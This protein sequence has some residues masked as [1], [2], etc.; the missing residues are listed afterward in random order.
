MF[1]V[2]FS[3]NRNWQPLN[4]AELKDFAAVTNIYEFRKQYYINIAPENAAARLKH[5]IRFGEKTSET[6]YWIPVRI[7]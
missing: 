3:R 6:R 7:Q 5:E 2:T 1:P 4:R